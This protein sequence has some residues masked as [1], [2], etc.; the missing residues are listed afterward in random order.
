VLVLKHDD[1]FS[2]VVVVNTIDDVN[3]IY[4]VTLDVMTNTF[5]S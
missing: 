3:I 5:V 4:K 2:V 1:I